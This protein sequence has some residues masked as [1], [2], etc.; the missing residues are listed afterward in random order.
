MPG[1][2]S[3][4][5]EHAVVEPHR[6]GAA[7]RAPLGGVVEQVG[8]RPLE[9]GALA[10][11]EPRRRCRRR[12]SRPARAAVP[13]R[14][15]RSTSSGRSTGSTTWVSGSSRAS[16]TR[17][18]IRVV[19]SSIWARTSS[20]SSRARRGG[21]SAASLSTW[22][23]RSRLVRSEV[24]G[25]RSSWPA[26]A[27]SWRCRSREAASAGEHLV[28]R[29]GQPGDL[30]VALDRQRAQ[31]LGAG[32]LLDRGGQPAH[33]AQAVA[34]DRPAGHAG[35]DHAG[36]AEEEHHD[37]ELARARP[38]GRRATGR[39][40]SCWPLSRCTATTRQ[41]V[42]V[43]AR[44]VRTECASSP[45]TTSI[46]GSPSSCRGSSGRSARDRRRCRW[47]SKQATQTSAAPRYSGG[48]SHGAVAAGS[49]RRRARPGRAASRRASP[50]AA[51]AR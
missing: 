22:L 34:G 6:D 16:S 13:A 39:A 25:V 48:T 8:D 14:S 30:V 1:P 15:A 38:P 41:R 26:S 50:G 47:P 17:S 49:S 44:S 9:A 40:P 19:S 18:P 51:S 24:S 11:H 28:E 42:A 37:P 45:S 27:T 33:R 46:S 43:G 32:D 36:E 3:S 29:R 21:R 12:R 20:S 7:G 10:D 23:S 4:T 31:V 2:W 5:V 35:R